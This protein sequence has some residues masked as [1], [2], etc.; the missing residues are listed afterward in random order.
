MKMQIALADDLP[1]D[2]LRLQTDIKQYSVSHNITLPDIH[3]F[4][5]GKDLYAHFVPGI[6]QA[7]FLDICMNEMNGIELA[8]M[9]RR[10]DPD[11]KIIFISTSRDYAF[12]AFP[13][14]PF[15]YLVK[16]YT[17]ESFRHVMDEL[18]L[19]FARPEPEITIR[20][21]RSAFRIPY[22]NIVS[23]FSS[24][25]SVDVYVTGNPPIRSIMTFSE[26]FEELSADSRFLLCN[27]GILA[28]MDHALKVED[29]VL[30]MKEGPSCPLR[31]RDQAKL[32]GQFSQYQLSRMKNPSHFSRS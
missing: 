29:N 13:I 22:R 27:R 26:I 4:Q 3:C 9:L 30:R 31:I 10:A 15:D 11:L 28:N 14:H 17:M 25:H 23:V 18:L 20:A 1:A 16:P 24:G 21:S 5:S 19:T 12:D 2:L 7:V 6:W 32:I 8:H